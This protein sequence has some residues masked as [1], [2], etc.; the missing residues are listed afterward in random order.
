MT[1]VYVVG[2]AD[3]KGE[4]LRYVRDLIAAQGV[5][6]ALVDVGIRSSGADADVT[7]QQVAAHHPEGAGA[8]FGND[9]G[10]AVTAMAQALVRFVQSRD[11]VGGIIGLGGSGG[12]AL[13]TPAMQVLPVGVPKVMVSTVASG[14][15]APYVGPSDICMIYSVTDVAGLNRISRQVLGN[16]AHAVAGMAA[17]RI[18]ASSADKPALGLT[19]FGVTT[20]CVQQ[21]VAALESEY[22]CL[23]FHATGTGGQSMEKLVDSGLV[24]G[25]IDVTTTEVCDL[26]FGGVFSAGSDRLGAII[27]TQTPYVGSCGALDMVNFGALATVPEKFKDRNLYVHNA[28]VTLM[29]TT[30]DENRQMGE[31]IGAKLNQCEGPVRFLLPEGGV[32]LID[33]PGQPFHDPEA[34]AALFAAL[35]KTVV[36][37]DS[38]RLI[39]LPHNVNDPEFAQALVENFKEIQS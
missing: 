5:A 10:A 17:H 18:P 13:V 28:Q 19:M 27:R 7:P 25:V 9:R 8:V 35:E 32:S 24:A 38:R 4:E 37:T 3:T 1:K 39:H 29:R 11:D 6:T 15:V 14:N 12:T 34:D 2:T 22:D 21:I 23:V 36:Q 16:A 31:W 20:P 30:V 26:L 33:A